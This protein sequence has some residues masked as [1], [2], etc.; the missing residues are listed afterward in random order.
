[1]NTVKRRKWLWIGG[2][3]V[4]LAVLLVASVVV[5][6]DPID[7]E[8]AQIAEDF[9]L[10][11]VDLQPVKVLQTVAGIRS[12]RT[13]RSAGLDE[14][15]YNELVASVE[16]CVNG[17]SPTP[18]GFRPLSPSPTYSSF[19]QNGDT[20]EA[21]N[22]YSNHSRYGELD[23]ELRFTRVSRNDATATLRVTHNELG[24]RDRIKQRL[25]MHWSA[26]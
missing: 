10:V 16:T 21:A 3:A 22:N 5:E 1:M 23:I 4:L 6:N 12:T 9:G 2:G 20:T 11:E 14:A 19:R 7:R 25:G 26:P 13:Y 15:R 17:I 18:V 8:L 24:L